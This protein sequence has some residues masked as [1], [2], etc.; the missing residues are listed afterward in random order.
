MP[1]K[2]KPKYF[3][4]I[5][6][7][8]L[9][10]VSA[11]L[12]INKVIDSQ[13]KLNQAADII[14]SLGTTSFFIDADIQDSI[15]IN[16]SFYIPVSIPVHVLMNVSVNVPLNMNVGVKKTLKIPYSVKINDLMPVDTFFR[17]P[18]GINAAVNDTI[19][20]NDRLKIKFWPGMK[21]PF[22]VNGSVQLNQTLSLN[23]GKI[24]VA[25]EIPIH[26]QLNDSIPVFLDFM[27]PVSDTLPMDMLIDSDAMISFYASLPVKGKLPLKMKTPVLIDF[28]KTP[29]KGKFDSLASV[30]RKI[31]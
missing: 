16:T 22:L 29:L 19:P 15:D 12:L 27:V 26:L 28:S 13:K 31:L 7:L 3:I 1:R 5:F 17:F 9:L 21:I 14:E 20:I 6:V 25:S 18:E 4:Y 23:P 10:A 8:L 24:R 11:I 2:Y 30:M